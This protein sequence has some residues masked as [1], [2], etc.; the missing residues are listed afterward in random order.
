VRILTLALLLVPLPARAG[1]LGEALTFIEET[2]GEDEIRGW[3]Q[4][5]VKDS[6]AALPMLISRDVKVGAPLESYD[7]TNSA[8]DQF[9][10]R[11][12]GEEKLL[13]RECMKLRWERDSLPGY[14]TLGK[15]RLD[16]RTVAD[17]IAVASRETQVP[18][19]LL[20]LIIAFRSGFRPGVISE[21]GHY[22]LMGLKPE[23]LREVGIPFG[24]LLDPRENVLVGARYIAKLTYRFKDLGLALAAFHDGPQVVDDAGG[25]IPKVRHIV[26]FVR[27]VFTLYYSTLYDVPTGIAAESMAFVITWID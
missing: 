12:S 4:L 18:A 5:A 7:C 2:A 3:E 11:T 9:V 10:M 23:L 14:R 8:I 22:G 26:W 21:D 1:D 17:I 25:Q 16:K 27:E 13:L 19:Y 6:N 20:E 15:G 24:D